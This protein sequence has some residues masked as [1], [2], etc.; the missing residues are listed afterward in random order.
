VKSLYGLPTAEFMDGKS[1]RP[2]FTCIDV[3]F[4]SDSSVLS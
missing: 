2:A 1:G 4:L 3:V